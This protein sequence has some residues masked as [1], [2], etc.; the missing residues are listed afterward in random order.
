MKKQSKLSPK[1]AKQVIAAKNVIAAVD[2][3][4]AAAKAAGRELTDEELKNLGYVETEGGVW[5]LP[6]PVHV[7]KIIAAEKASK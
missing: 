1:V 2:A 3:A 5:E 4:E 7:A 6:I